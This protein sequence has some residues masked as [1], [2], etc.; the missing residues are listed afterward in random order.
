MDVTPEPSFRDLIRDYQVL[1]QPDAKN[2]S[3]T[4]KLD[5][6]GIQVKPHKSIIF[7]RKPLALATMFT[8][9]D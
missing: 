6:Q 8:K 2:L 9:Q 5:P 7:S 1:K 4:A 3:K